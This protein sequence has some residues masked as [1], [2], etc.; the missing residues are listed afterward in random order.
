MNVPNKP[1]P[2]KHRESCLDHALAYARRGWTVLPVRGKAAA[3]PWKPLQTAPPAPAD[4]ERLFHEVSI[5]GVAALMGDASGGLVCRDFDLRAAYRS[6]AKHHPVLAR[7]LPTS[8]TGRGMHVF[9]RGPA[10]FLNLGGTGEY[11]GDSHHYCVLPPSRHPAGG[12]YRWIVPLPD[13]PLPEVAD[14]GRAGLLL[15][16]VRLP[17]GAAGALGDGQEHPDNPSTHQLI[18]CV[19]YG[20]ADAIAATLPS[21]PAQ[22][23]RQVFQLARRLKAIMPDATPAELKGIVTEWHGQAL[24]VVRTKDF[25]ETWT[26]FQVAWM[27]VKRPHGSSVQAAYEAARRAPLGPIDGSV[28]LG[29]L[30]ALCR[31]LDGGGR[32]F[33]LAVRTVERLFGVGRMTAWRMLRA[34]EFN[35]VIKPIEKGT[36]KARHATTWR[37]TDLGHRS[38]DQ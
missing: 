29:A 36:L 8:E 22:R 30:A 10:G 33:Y 4:L 31:I 34:L 18:A 28:E 25:G 11:R 17:T 32:P 38:S 3:V 23:N 13:G 20:V 15:P 7:T 19:P 35:G 21:G 24:P 6:W 5:T 2:F 37:F 16:G 27:A 12:A 26:D 1:T 14:P 9:F